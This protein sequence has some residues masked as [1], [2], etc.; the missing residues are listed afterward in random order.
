MPRALLRVQLA[1]CLGVATLAFCAI[2]SQADDPKPAATPV[3]VDPLRKF[4]EDAIT[5]TARRDLDGRSHTPWQIV[6][7]VLGMR[8]QFFVRVDGQRMSALDWFHNQSATYANEP[9]FEVTEFGGR[10]HP[11]TKPMLFEGHPTQFLAYMTM[12]KLPLDFTVKSGDRTLTIQDLVNGAQKE[13]KTGEEPGWTLWALT[14]Y[15]GVDATWENKDGEP[16]SIERL[17]RSQTYETV[18]TAACGGTHGLFALAYARQKY[19]ETGKPLRGVWLEADQKVRRYIAEA[20]ALQ[21]ADGSF[22][23]DFFKGKKWGK[24]VDERLGPSGHVF[25]FLMIALSREQLDEQWARNAIFSVT[26]DLEETKSQTLS[27]A[28]L[29][30]AVDGLHIWL[31]RTAPKQAAAPAVAKTEAISTPAPANEPAP[32][33]AGSTTGEGT[34]KPTTTTGASVASPTKE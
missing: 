34:A 1:I 28:P 8:E 26:R 2:P 23:V 11:F 27:V 5:I 29:Y 15:L 21:N 7:G 25:E 33:S 12:S 20:K 22:S 3:L 30:H 32:A 31:E 4:A 6:H 24:T 19:L 17:V 13:V 10:G 9:Y 16:W 14:H 18:N